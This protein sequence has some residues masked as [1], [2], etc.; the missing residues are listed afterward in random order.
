M[1]VFAMGLIF[2]CRAVHCSY[3]LLFAW[4]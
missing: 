1:F 3:E 2:T 4:I